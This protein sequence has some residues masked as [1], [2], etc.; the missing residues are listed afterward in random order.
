M[1]WKP[2]LLIYHFSLFSL[3]G[4]VTSPYFSAPVWALICNLILKFKK[5]LFQKPINIWL[6]IS[7]YLSKKTKTSLSS[8]IGSC[9]P[10]DKCNTIC[11]LVS[12]AA[13]WKLA[14]C[15]SERKKRQQPFQPW[16][17]KPQGEKSDLETRLSVSKQSNWIL[18]F[19]CTL[20]LNLNLLQ[21]V[22]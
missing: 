11:V 14:L 3:E 8:L 7:T 21:S 1:P 19:I 5:K 17:H 2:L 10:C 16:S 12:A 9:L 20:V 6:F 15:W 4:E 18:A 13:F 22:K